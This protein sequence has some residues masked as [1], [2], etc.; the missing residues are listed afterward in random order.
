MLNHDQESIVYGVIRYLPTTDF[1]SAHAHRRTNWAA[2]QGLPLG[3]D[4]EWP[5]LCR[6]MFSMPGGHQFNGTYQTQLIHFAASYKAIEYEWEK[7]LQQFEELLKGMYWVSATV[8]LETELSGKHTFSWH[9]EHGH[10][11]SD[12]EL[13]MNCEWEREASFAL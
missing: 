8:H 12:A 11:P 3:L 1:L 10:A 7:W 6:E 13:C 9:S 4:D 5:L 2:I